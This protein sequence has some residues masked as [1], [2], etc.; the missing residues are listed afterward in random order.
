MMRFQHSNG[1]PFG[2]GVNKGDNFYYSNFFLLAWQF[3][4]TAKI[5]GRNSPVHPVIDTLLRVI[6]EI[7]RFDLTSDTLVGFHWLLTPERVHLK[8]AVHCTA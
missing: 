8:V 7:R 6:A 1:N 4:G 3:F 5:S 2:H